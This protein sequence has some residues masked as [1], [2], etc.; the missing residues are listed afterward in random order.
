MENH[1]LEYIEIKDFKCFK[2]FKAEGF[3]RVNLIGGKN[4][5]GKTA[6]MEACFINSYSKNIKCFVRALFNIKFSRENT[7]VLL[8]DNYNTKIYIEQSNKILTNSN[9]NLASFQIEDTN[10]IKQYIFSFNKQYIKVNINDFS[11]EMED[12]EN[13]NFIDNFGLSNGEILAFYSAIQRKKEEEFL[14]NIL[15]TFESSIQSF[16]I[17]DE[18]PQCEVNGIYREVTEFGDGIR[19]LISIVTSLFTSENGYLFIDEIDNGIHY[20][21]L[22]EIWTIILEV[23]K[24]LD[25]QIFATTHSKEC[26]E[27][28][29]RVSKKLEDQDE[30]DKDDVSFIEL[31]KNKENK[32]DSIVYNYE[33]IQSEIKQ[34]HEIRGW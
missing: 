26:I 29:A 12:I 22:D 13:I 28:Y 5:V 27:S 21:K 7:N 17:I 4:N 20:S 14:N 9:Q 34:N 19:H 6:F 15:N 16:K 31:G 3:K 11:Y 1:L 30:I 8:G 23:S 10:G 18:K 2:D 25:V 33:M 24:K 32:L